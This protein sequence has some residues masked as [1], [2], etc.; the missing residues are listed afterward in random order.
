MT[1][2]DWRSTDTSHFT[3]ARKQVFS[4]A[5]EKSSGEFVKASAGELLMVYALVRDWVSEAIPSNSPM[6]AKVDSIK[7]LVELCDLICKAMRERRPHKLRALADEIAFTAKTYLDSVVFAYGKEV[8]RI[9]HHE[10]LHLAA[11]LIAD[12][13]A[14]GCARCSCS[15]R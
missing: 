1:K 8:V 3:T 2:Y 14:I 4:L 11:Q 7:V 9:K 15:V 6:E 13:A 10:L 12:Q 5:R